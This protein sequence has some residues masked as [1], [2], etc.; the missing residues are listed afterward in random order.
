MSRTLD[1]RVLCNA[2]PEAL[3]VFGSASRIASFGVGAPGECIGAA[4]LPLHARKYPYTSCIVRTASRTQSSSYPT[5][6]ELSLSE[7]DRPAQ[8]RTSGDNAR[9]GRQAK[10]T[11]GRLCAVRSGIRR[12][13]LEIIRGVVKCDTAVPRSVFVRA[14]EISACVAKQKRARWHQ[15]VTRPGTRLRAVLKAAR[16]NYGYNKA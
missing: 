16:R 13:T 10:H 3:G 12:E 8:A 4:S 11:K 7:R 15:L 14:L 5:S 6:P 2:N 9:N 1:R